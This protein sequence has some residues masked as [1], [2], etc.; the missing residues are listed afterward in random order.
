M[1][2]FNFEIIITILSNVSP[3][4]RQKDIVS[5]NPNISLENLIITKPIKI[6]TIIDITLRGNLLNKNSFQE[7]L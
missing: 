5:G 6:F 1:G 2:N 4:T 7:K 3:A